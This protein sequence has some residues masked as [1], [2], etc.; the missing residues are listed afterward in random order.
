[1]YSF[2]CISRTGNLG[3]TSD[4]GSSR[5]GRNVHATF[6][7][8]LRKIVGSRRSYRQPHVTGGLLN[9]HALDSTMSLTIAKLA[10]F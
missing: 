1:M 8:V 9:Y 7:W 3:A 5:R 6:G 10:L 2:H 4:D